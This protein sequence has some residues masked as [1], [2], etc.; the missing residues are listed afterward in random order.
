MLV[1]LSARVE[2][3]DAALLVAVRRSK[4]VDVSF[5]LKDDGIDRCFCGVGEVSGS[6]RVLWG[7]R[8]G[9]VREGDVL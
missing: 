5:M 2:R 6:K 4:L 3:C 8:E 9:E 1:L 7:A